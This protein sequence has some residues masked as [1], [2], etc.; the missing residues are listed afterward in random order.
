MYGRISH[1][2]QLTRENGR[3][4]RLG[5]DRGNLPLKMRGAWRIAITV[6]EEQTCAENPL[7]AEGL[8]IPNAG[9]AAGFN[10]PIGSQSARPP[11]QPQGSRRHAMSTGAS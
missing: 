1:R 2:G 5:I 3:G 6:R 8:C 9:D 4:K 7:V 11:L 10:V